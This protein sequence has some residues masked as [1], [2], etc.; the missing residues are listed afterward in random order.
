MPSPRRIMAFSPSMKTGAAGAKQALGRTWQELSTN[1]E[2]HKGVE[3]GVK[4]AGEVGGPV[5][6]TSKQPSKAARADGPV[7]QTGK[8]G[9]LTLIPSVGANG[10]RCRAAPYPFGSGQQSAGTMSALAGKKMLTS[11]WPGVNQAKRWPSRGITSPVK[12]V[13]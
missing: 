6:P 4:T 11:A 8:P 12:S 2:L 13:T 10:E 9:R 7:P 3:F 5:S 1:Q